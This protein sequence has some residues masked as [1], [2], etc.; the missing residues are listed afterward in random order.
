MR[1]TNEEFEAEVFRRSRV[2]M[3][4]RQMRRRHM[5]TGALAFAGCFVLV[6]A[7]AV[8]LPNRN[9]SDLMTADVAMNENGGADSA[10]ADAEYA[11]ESSEEYAEQAEEAEMND[12]VEDEND[13][14][15]LNQD[16]ITGGEAFSA[17]NEQK[18]QNESAASPAS[19]VRPAHDK[20]S[21]EESSEAPSDED[22]KAVNTPEKICESYGIP[23]PPDE[24][25]GFAESEEPAVVGRDLDELLFRYENARGKLSFTVMHPSDYDREHETD[26]I[27]YTSAVPQIK[28]ASFLCGSAQIIIELESDDPDAEALL[29]E[30]AEALK[31]YLSR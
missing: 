26:G 22:E 14:L 11:E 4:E 5:L 29:K 31:A 12:W 21:G 24:I 6:T 9:K 10:A 30:A 16:A 28:S 23:V 1:M 3:K 25:A 17:K 20:A 7:G 15:H 2:Y 18:N 13:S 27:R 8:M 19:T